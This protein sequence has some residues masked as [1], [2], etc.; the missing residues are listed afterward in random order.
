MSNLYVLS[1][2]RSH[3]CVQTPGPKVCPFS[4]NKVNKTFRDL[5]KEN[6]WS[7][8]HSPIGVIHSGSCGNQH[9]LC[10]SLYICTTSHE[11]QVH[12]RAPHR[13]LGQSYEGVFLFFIL[14]PKC[15]VSIHPSDCEYSLSSSFMW[16]N[17]PPA[18][19]IYTSTFV[20]FPN[21]FVNL[22][23]EVF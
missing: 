7:R 3:V 12:F 9:S 16:Y 19:T 14:V 5:G 10:L 20:S 2:N 23:Q 8:K 21:C 6:S 18:P 15:V 11:S 17:L 1:D 4:D 13:L 22:D